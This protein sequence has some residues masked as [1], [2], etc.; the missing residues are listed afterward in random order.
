MAS[1]MHQAPTT[2]HEMPLV[3]NKDRSPC[4]VLEMDCE[5]PSSPARKS[6]S[7][8]S[9]ADYALH[10]TAPFCEI[11]TKVT[12]L[13]Q[14]SSPPRL[15][16]GGV[17]SNSVAASAPL[18]QGLGGEAFTLSRLSPISS[19]S[20]TTTALSESS[21]TSELLH[22]STYHSDND[23]EL[24]EEPLDLSQLS[25][26]APLGKGSTASV[27]EVAHRSSE[28]NDITCH[29]A[30]KVMKSNR[31]YEKQFYREC[32]VLEL[33]KDEPFVVKLVAAFELVSIP[34]PP[35]GAFFDAKTPVRALALEYCP[36]GEL[37]NK[38]RLL[39]FQIMTYFVP[40]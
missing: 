25:F 30:L 9:P 3:S 4:S 40:H 18:C 24:Q 15:L 17:D 8:L 16:F 1:Y 13:T 31:S 19:L 39:L 20:S 36:R 37:V 21:P 23:C 7:V 14:L 26:V 33:L 27:F 28:F 32:T 38:L 11:T 35:E 34:S 10:S 22:L 12:K 2:S 5:S 6:S 29:L